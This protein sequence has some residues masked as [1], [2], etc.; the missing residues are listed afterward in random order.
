MEG[1]LGDKICLLSSAKNLFSLQKGM[2]RSFSKFLLLFFLSNSNCNCS[3]NIARHLWWEWPNLLLMICLSVLDMCLSSCDNYT[4]VIFCYCCLCFLRHFVAMISKTFTQMLN[5]LAHYLISFI[6]TMNI[7]KQQAHYRYMIYIQYVLYS[8]NTYHV[9]HFSCMQWSLLNSM[10]HD[11]DYAQK[12]NQKTQLWL[13]FDQP[14][15]CS[16]PTIL[17]AIDI[18]SRQKRNKDKAERKKQWL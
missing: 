15:V 2:F 16:C 11:F 8:C 9:T 10:K 13:H 1:R 18:C 12:Y 5:T 7:K 14:N 6:S 4:S 17:T 3:S